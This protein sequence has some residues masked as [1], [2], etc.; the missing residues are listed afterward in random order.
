MDR[1]GIEADLNANGCAV[2]PAEFS[3]GEFKDFRYPL[4]DV[5]AKLRTTRLPNLAAIVNRQTFG[6]IFHNTP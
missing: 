4:P 6:I 5:V 1:Q 2:G 3:K